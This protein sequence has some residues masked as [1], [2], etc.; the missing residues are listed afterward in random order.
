[1]EPQYVAKNAGAKVCIYDK[2]MTVKKSLVSGE[3]T[4]PYKEVASVE[5]GFIGLEINTKD[6]RCYKVS[7]RNSDKEKIK[8]LIIEK[9]S[10]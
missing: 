2:Y 7:L 10:E 6:K 8:Q 3:V 1:M 5:S 9:I 4:I